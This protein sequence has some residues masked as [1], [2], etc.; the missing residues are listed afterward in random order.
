MENINKKGW[1]NV[2]NDEIK[3]LFQF[4]RD[5]EKTS[6]VILLLIA[7]ITGPITI[8]GAL[9]FYV[10]AFNRFMHPNHELP[11]FYPMRPIVRVAMIIGA[12][13]AWLVVIAGVYFAKEYAPELF[14]SAGMAFAYLGGNLIISGI[15]YAV[16][17]RWQVGMHNMLMHTDKFASARYASM[18]ELMQYFAKE[19]LYVGGGFAFKDKGHLL[20]VASTRSG[21]GTN[22]IIPNILRLKDY[23]GNM[24]IIDVK[25]E[26]CAIT[27]NAL[28]A[29]GKRV[30]VLN[31]FEI[32]PEFIKGNSA[33]NPLSILSDKSSPHLVDDVMLIAENL[34]P[35]KPNDHNEYFTTA[36]RQIIAAILLHIVTSDKFKNPTLSDLWWAL[37][38]SG[39]DWDNLLADMATCTDPINGEAVRGA[40]NEIVKQMASPESWASC[41]S[42]ALQ[43]TD[44]FK[45]SL[46]KKSI[47][48]GFD[49][50]SLT[51]DNDTVIFITLPV[52]KLTSH[53]RWLR[54][55]TTT[56]MRAIVRKPNQD[57][58]TTFLIDE[59]G[60]Q[61]YNTEFEQCLATYAGMGISLWLI[62]QDI[63]Q[64]VATYGEHKWQSVVANCQVRLFSGVK[65]NYTA[66]YISEAMGR[67]TK[68]FY[69]RGRFGFV[70]EAEHIERA[71]ATPGEVKEISRDKFLLF[72]G[73]NSF[74]QIE[75]QPYYSMPALKRNGKNLYSQNP[76]IKGNL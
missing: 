21:K 36:G 45:S 26:N 55:V 23:K 70:G 41:L 24:I 59:A 56:L 38:L 61:G 31:P 5:P 10:R 15:V 69:S 22:I 17:R 58:H 3:T 75:K 34:V 53:A 35:I 74:I 20:L 33:Y 12:V 63:P 27:A 16:Y 13:L 72:V 66:D 54:L 64:I 6:K 42:N 19:G 52:D 50:Y 18:E 7:M 76:Y 44:I 11:N 2:T 40:A 43:A 1:F 57:V 71:L 68:T 8:I 62:Y 47:Q 9:V 48:T 29:L 49:P 28:R 67:T 39:P 60:V 73:E 51:E 30:I 14:G 4:R 65:D 46:L 32:L 25:G 37:R